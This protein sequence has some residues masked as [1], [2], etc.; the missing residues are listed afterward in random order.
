M[1]GSKCFLSGRDLYSDCPTSL[2]RTQQ[3]ARWS[4]SLQVVEILLPLQDK[5]GSL[6]P[7]ERFRTLRDMLTERFGGLTAFTRAPADGIWKDRKDRV[8]RDNIIV[9]EVMAPNIDKA[10]WRQL[11]RELERSFRQEQIVIRSHAIQRL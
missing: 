4:D 11:R 9:F 6:L 5:D 7:E 3:D 2:A 10:W 1:K 8:R